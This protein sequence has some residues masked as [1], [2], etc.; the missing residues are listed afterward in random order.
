MFV[1]VRAG[2]LIGLL[3]GMLTGARSAAEP[4]RSERPA[5]GLDVVPLLFAD[6]S[7]VQERSGVVR[8]IHPARTRA[9]PV[10]RPEN[11]WEG[12]R[13]YIYGSVYRDADTGDYRMWY[14]GRPE[15]EGTK[16]QNRAPSLRS[17]GSDLILYA[18]SHDGVKWTRP[19]LGLHAFDGSSDNNIVFNL[20][21]PAI[22]IDRFEKDPARRYK[23]MGSTLQG[24]R[25]AY[26]ADGL[27]W[28]EYPENPVLEHFDT[29]TLAQNPGTGEFL[30]YH[31]RP[32]V[33]RGFY[34]R[35]VWLSRSKDFQHWSTPE[36]V[37]VPDA[38]DDEWATRVGERTEVYN[39]SVYPHATGFLGFPTMFRVMK[40]RAAG[41]LGPGQSPLDGPIDVQLV[42]SADGRSWRRTW[43]RQ[44]VIPRGAPGAF[45]AGAILGLASTVV[46]SDTE[47]WVYYTALTTGHGSPMPP[48]RISIGRAEWRLHGFA[49]LDA[50]PD[51]GRVETVALALPPGGLTINADASRGE[52]RVALLEADGKPLAGFGF[53][54][55]PTLNADDLRWTVRWK[56]GAPP[57][58][59]PL[60]VLIEMKNARLYS[61]A[62]AKP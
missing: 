49:S 8:T 48:K 43:P 24:Y 39:M 44:N 3:A 54:D 20:H 1:S 41:E 25:V 22:L 31:K 27:N 33:E 34:R 9:E 16:P 46:D 51:G 18:T 56:N 14:Q 32:A 37:F 21:S 55:S 47:T 13:T 59:R 17:G 35:A 38:T 58:D 11:S 15:P 40:V 19:A 2:L 57:R 30:A 61:L 23:L 7:G 6:D 26:S 28:I 5:P 53:E 36:L 42:T 62:A 12:M 60:R 50:G 52:L 29:I 10:L 4:A 45:D